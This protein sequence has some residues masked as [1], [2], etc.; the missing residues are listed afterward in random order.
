MTQ[1]QLNAW[2]WAAPFAYA[3]SNHNSRPSNRLCAKSTR[4]IACAIEYAPYAKVSLCNCDNG[5]KVNAPILAP[6]LQNVVGGNA[7]ELLQ[8]VGTIGDSEILRQKFS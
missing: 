4:V 2:N 8:S 1:D 5:V 6:G 7:A 3:R